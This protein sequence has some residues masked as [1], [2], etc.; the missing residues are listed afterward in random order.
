MLYRQPDRLHDH[1]RARRVFRMRIL[2]GAVVSLFV[3][4]ILFGRA[5]W[6]QIAQHDYYSAKAEQN[7]T[8]IVVLPP[9]RG[10]IFDAQ[11]EVV[12]DNVA[13][14]QVQI[15]P[16]HSRDVRAELDMLARVLELDSAEVD[17]LAERIRVGR[18]FDPV[19]VKADLDEVERARIA[20]LKPWLRG[21]EIVSSLKRVYPYRELLAHVVGYVGRINAEDVKRIDADAYQGT[22][23]IGKTGIERQYEDRLHGVPGYRVVEVDALGREIEVLETVRPTPGH[24]LALSIDVGLQGIAAAALGE[25]A[26]A[27]VAED[28]RDGAIR[29]MVS[30]PSFDPNLFVDGI[31]RDTY[32]ALLEDPDRPLYNRVTTAAYPPG[33]TIKPLMGVVGMEDG[34]IEPDERFFA[35]PYYQI[36]G[37][38]HR[39][40]DWRKWGHGWVDFEESVFRSVDVYYYDLAYRMGID[41]MHEF[42]TDFGLGQPTGIDLPG[43]KSGLIPSRDWKRRVK[44]EIWFPGETV[45][46][47]IGQGYMLTTILQ[48]ADMTATLAQSGTRHRPWLVAD[49]RGMRPPVEIE[50]TDA[51]RRAR[52]AMLAVV[53]HE[54]GTANKIAAPYP[55]AGKTGT[56]QVFSVAQD[57]E[58]DAEE[59]ERRL[60]DHALFVGFAP[61]DDPELAVAVIAEHG[62]SGSGTAAPIARKVMDFWFGVEPDSEIQPEFSEYGD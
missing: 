12:A 57:E 24:D 39:Y 45:I 4:L 32:R 48:L 22:Q 26:G 34:L 61:F 3:I 14:Y 53:E 33:S 29:A 23:Y 20:R 43:E 46:A 1:G 21:T 44:D 51:W 36:P 56:A 31:G 35:G 59:L 30:R 25:Y 28:P 7:R 54:R 5:A 47:G 13:T 40:R 38:K 60:H 41:R 10:R 9:E 37:N 55:I 6:L 11:G 58:Y 52:E 2:L 15:T 50:R 27:V 42:L 16:E 62:G 18:R 49:N 8:R 17:A 19:L